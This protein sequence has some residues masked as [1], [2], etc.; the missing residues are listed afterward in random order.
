MSSIYEYVDWRH[1][2]QDRGYGNEYS[3]SIKG[4]EF[5]D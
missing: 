2:A 3:G 4:E 5:L 1:P